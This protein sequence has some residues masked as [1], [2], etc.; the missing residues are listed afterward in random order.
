MPGEDFSSFIRL[1]R[2]LQVLRDAIQARALANPDA[3][4]GVARTAPR[5]VPPQVSGI[6]ADTNLNT[7]TVTWSPVQTVNLLRYEVEVATDPDFTERVKLASTRA[8][9]WT[10]QEGNPDTEYWV[11]ARAIAY[12]PGGQREGPWSARVNT[13][14]GKVLSANIT[15][16]A[17]SEI[18]Q[19]VQ[20][21]G[22]TLLDSNPSTSGGI[23]VDETY[24]PLEVGVLDADSIVVPRVVFEFDIASLF[25][26][27]TTNR[28][29]LELLRRRDGETTASDVVADSA[30][31][32]FFSTVPDPNITTSLLRQ[33]LSSFTTFDQPG[34][35]AW[36]YRVKVT[37]ESGAGAN[38]LRF[39]GQALNME[40]IQTKR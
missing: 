20:T 9:E 10:Y 37:L 1:Q 40:F 30:E 34:A 38:R 8:T 3:A 29:T 31:F 27:N 23:S 22:F 16:G 19:F 39:Q 11:R 26:A 32:D 5:G 33:T 14:T 36:E 4:A 13:T 6:A 15:V 12:T 35:G 18:H 25:V 17:A 7:I 28:M 2:E 24:G 21:S